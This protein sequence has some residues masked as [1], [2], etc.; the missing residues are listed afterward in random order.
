MKTE[1]VYLDHPVLGW[2]EHEPTRNELIGGE[3]PSALLELGAL[4]T[5]D[6]HR[7]KGD[8]PGND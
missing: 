3:S 2:T 8:D 7:K 1:T 4:L 6:P 5:S